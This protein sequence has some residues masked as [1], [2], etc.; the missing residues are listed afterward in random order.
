[1][2]INLLFDSFL[3]TSSDSFSPSRS[4]IHLPKWIN[5]HM[6][7]DVSIIQLIIFVLKMTICLFLCLQ[8][9]IKSFSFF[10]S[11]GLIWSNYNPIILIPTT[12]HICLKSWL[13]AL[14]CILIP[15]I[16]LHRKRSLIY[17][18]HGNQQI[19]I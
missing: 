19:I 18:N 5:I 11:L 3:D 9:N 1:M 17:H 15:L 13:I 10:S 8:V 6:I 12:V 2:I 7:D 14:V 16:V 4:H